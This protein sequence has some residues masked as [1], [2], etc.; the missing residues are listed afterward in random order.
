MMQ[1]IK[2]TRTHAKVRS[3]GRGLGD[4]GRIYANQANLYES[5]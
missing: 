5:R 3:R 1:N 4:S 2:R